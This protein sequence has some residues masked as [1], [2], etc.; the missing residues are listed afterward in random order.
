MNKFQ[1]IYGYKRYGYKKE[2]IFIPRKHKPLITLIAYFAV[3]RNAN[4]E[5]LPRTSKYISGKESFVRKKMKHLREEFLQLFV[6]TSPNKL[7]LLL[8]ITINNFPTL[9]NY[10]I[11]VLAYLSFEG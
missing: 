9:K 5:L 6:E 10:L 11:K 1:P 2:C 3:S 7:L 4:Q 8:K